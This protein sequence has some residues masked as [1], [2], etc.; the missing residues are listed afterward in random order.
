MRVPLTWLRDYVAI[1]DTPEELASRL[2]FAGLEVDLAE[3]Q[4]PAEAAVEL[5]EA[6]GACVVAV[7]HEGESIAVR[8]EE[9]LVRLGERGP[10][11]GDHVGVAGIQ[12]ETMAAVL[13]ADA[14]SRHYDTGAEAGED[15]GRDA[16][17]RRRGERAGAVDGRVSRS[18][19]AGRTR[20][21]VPALA[22]P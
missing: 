15:P 1:S 12:A 14:G 7:E 11:Q 9:L 2:T 16:D 20:T 18:A 4:P 13:Q 21:D 8:E 22:R 5:T 3:V 10:H 17:P 6:L 19:L